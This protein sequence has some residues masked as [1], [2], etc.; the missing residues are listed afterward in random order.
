LDDDP[1]ATESVNASKATKSQVVFV[2]RRPRH[3]GSEEIIVYGCCHEQL[4][5]PSPLGVGRLPPLVS[6]AVMAV[7][8]LASW[9]IA[10]R[11]H[12]GTSLAAH[13]SC[14][15]KPSS[16]SVQRSHL[17]QLQLPPHLET[18]ILRGMAC[19]YRC[20]GLIRLNQ[21]VPSG[22]SLL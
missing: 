16:M 3:V 19:F 1:E 5:P 7:A 12:L 10:R 18:L 8:T 22:P 13:V 9:C 15:R 2:E 14:R 17:K 4:P 6:H 20:P 21:M 11:R